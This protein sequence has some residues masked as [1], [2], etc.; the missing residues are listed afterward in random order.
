MASEE[1]K[2]RI[3]IS[4]V[5]MAIAWFVSGVASGWSLR[6]ANAAFAFFL[7]SIPFFA[8]AWVL[9]GIPIIAL[10]NRIL[11]IPQILL[12]ICGAAAGALVMHFPT[13]G[14][15]IF[16]GKEQH[17]DWSVLRE[18]SYWRGWPAFGAAIGA[19]VTI[20]YRWLLRWANRGDRGSRTQP[21]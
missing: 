19:G 12:A 15:A 10:G 8:V 2:T 20:M 16:L 11:R 4:L 18:W 5:S 6:D 3:G 21:V 7:W 1:V 17:V 13:I 14:W 9:M